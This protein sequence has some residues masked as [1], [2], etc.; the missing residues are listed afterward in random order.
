MTPEKFIATW[1]NNALAERAGSWCAFPAKGF[2]FTK[3]SPFVVSLSN[4]E[5]APGLWH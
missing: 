5:R 3:G 1:K 4:H 2:P